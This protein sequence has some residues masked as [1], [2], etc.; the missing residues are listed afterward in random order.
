MEKD[1]FGTMRGMWSHS[2]LQRILCVRK[3][4][5]SIIQ[6]LIFLYQAVYPSARWIVSYNSDTPIALDIQSK[7]YQVFVNKK[8]CNKTQTKTEKN[9]TN[10]LRCLS[11]IASASSLV[12]S[13]DA[14]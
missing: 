3:H 1:V 6:L 14:I 13:V 5:G 12:D 7:A 8:R 4:E 11:K 2:C 10:I 9:K